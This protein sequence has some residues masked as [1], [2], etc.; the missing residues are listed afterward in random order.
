MLEV[1]NSEVVGL[2]APNKG[3]ELLAPNPVPA[4]G[5]D[6][7]ADGALVAAPPNGVVLAPNAPVVVL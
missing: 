5:V 3:L 2:A 7:K 1:P 4:V 6:P